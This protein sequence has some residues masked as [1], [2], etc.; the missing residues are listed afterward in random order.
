V[1]VGVYELSAIK[2]AKA[3]YKG[4]KSKVH[5]IL[6]VYIERGEIP[7]ALRSDAWLIRQNALRLLSALEAFLLRFNAPETVL[8]AKILAL[9]LEYGAPEQLCPL[10][11]LDGVGI[12]QATQL[13]T[14][15]IRSA[16]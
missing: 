12:K 3:H 9:R 6:K 15:G 7:E 2:G 8:R 16:V 11:Q 13:Y 14:Q 4:P 10:L 5:A 1:V